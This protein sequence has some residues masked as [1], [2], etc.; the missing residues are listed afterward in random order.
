MIGYRDFS[1]KTIVVAIDFS[2][3]SYG[4]VNYAEQLARRFSA[5]ILFLHVVPPNGRPKAELARL[6]DAAEVELQERASALLESGI[7]YFSIVRTGSVPDTVQSLITERDADLLVMGTQGKGY[8]KDEGLGSVAESLLR[9]VSCPVLT[10]GRSVRQDACE[11]THTRCILFPTDF[12]DLSRATLAYTGS[13]TKRLGARL[14]LLHVEG[15]EAGQ[16]AGHPA[17]FQDQIEA[18]GDPTLVYESMTRLGEPAD[19]VLA[20]SAEKRADFIVMGVHRRDQAGRA[21]H[22]GMAFDIVRLAKCPVFT[23][24]FQAERTQAEMVAEELTE[25]DEHRRQRQ[26]LMPQRS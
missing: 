15:S 17:E 23:L 18:L 20:V 11:N 6:L 9:T 8:K 14:L 7:R 12:S 3:A 5:K 2:E 19:V 22:Y 21:P 24:L 25:A 13:L 10:V 16:S 1:M 26:R 4:A